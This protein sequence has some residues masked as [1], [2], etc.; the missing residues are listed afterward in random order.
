MRKERILV[1]GGK[2]NEILSQFDGPVI[3]NNDIKMNKDLIVYGT[4]KFTGDVEFTDTSNEYTTDSL[5]KAN[6]KLQDNKKSIIS[7]G[8]GI[9]TDASDGSGDCEMYHDGS[10]T[11]IDQL[12]NGTGNLQLQ[13]GGVTKIEVNPDGA[14]L[15]GVTNSW[16]LTATGTITLMHL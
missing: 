7:N 11:R 5:F 13:H 15:S 14:V 16:N 6:I 2:S 4:V 12:S 3:F 1:E 9:A 8:A 10:N